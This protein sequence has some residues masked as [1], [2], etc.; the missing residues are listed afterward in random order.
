M[1]ERRSTDL[2]WNLF[3]REIEAL[4]QRRNLSFGALTSQA[5]IHP[6]KVQ[7][8]RRALKKPIFHTLNPEDLE[9]V[10]ITFDITAEEE[11][12][13]HAALLATA[14]ER[15][16]MDRIDPEN[17]LQAAEELLPLLV[18]GL[19]ERANQRSGIGAI[20]GTSARMRAI[21]KEETKIED[22]LEDVLE[23]FD[24]AMLALHLSRQVETHTEQIRQLRKA[25][26]DFANFIE[27]LDLLGQNDPY[28]KTF[29][30]WQL[31]YQ[32]AQHFLIVT[33]QQLGQLGG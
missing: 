26:D 5:G 20:R 1:K 16:L 11:I 8:L 30:L 22:L 3:A 21:M 12:R 28:I 33:K 29:E 23:G 31:W 13:L 25:L 24:R 7:R 6:G 9:A 17:A 14:V 19:R 27:E 15:L 2:K 10:I 18:K 32:E 4:L